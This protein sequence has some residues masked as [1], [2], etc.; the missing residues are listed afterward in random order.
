M[1]HSFI[2]KYSGLNSLVHKLDPRT[3]LISSLAFIIAIVM[4]PAS[5]WKV[6]A[7][8]LITLLALVYLSRLP[9]SYVLKRSL[10]IVPFVFIIAVFVPFFKHGQEAWSGNIGMWHIVV[11]YQGLNVLINVVI[12]AWLS[13]ICLTILTST[14]KFT[15]MLKGMYLLKVPAVFVQILSFMYRYLFVLVDQAMRM[16][17]ARDSR[18][19][20]SN[21]KLILKTMGNIIGMLFIRSYER[22]E[23]IYVAMLSRGYNSEIPVVNK[24]RYRLPDVCFASALAVLII[25][26]AVLWW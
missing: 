14:T 8:Y 18:N 16:Q 13:M 26:P 15:D 9:F 17:M 4:T 3:K 22:G 5:N 25:F 21:R 2:D 11:T 20:G 19:F 10:L 12:R 23:R 1:K 24:L 7:I 6:Y